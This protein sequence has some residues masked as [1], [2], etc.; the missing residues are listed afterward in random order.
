M[1][2]LLP[3]PCPCLF[4]S[5]DA[6]R[7]MFDVRESAVRLREVQCPGRFCIETDV[8]VGDVCCGKRLSGIVDNT[9]YAYDF[10]G[11]YLC[12]QSV[13]ASFLLYPRMVEEQMVEEGGVDDAALRMQMLRGSSRKLL[14]Q[15]S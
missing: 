5:P 12:C 6:A 4:I 3:K 14:H 11:E 1:G 15:F 8:A 9:C 10:G 7:H 2:V 13:S